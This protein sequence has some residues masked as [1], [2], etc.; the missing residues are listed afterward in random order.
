MNCD[1]IFDELFLHPLATRSREKLA[2]GLVGRNL[3]VEPA[4]CVEEP[5]FVPVWRVG[6]GVD[7]LDD[8]VIE[9][10]ARAPSRVIMTDDHPANFTQKGSLDDKDV[11]LAALEVIS[12]RVELPLARVA[13]LSIDG[14]V[15]VGVGT[16]A[17]FV[18]GVNRDLVPVTVVDGGTACGKFHEDVLLHELVTPKHG[19]LLGCLVQHLN[20]L[21]VPVGPTQYTGTVVF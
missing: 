19:L 16:R 20:H 8:D 12:A 10:P 14:D 7:V 1:K 9:L 17:A 18:R 6:C 15:N 3:L 4:V 13:V 2:F 11:R 21:A 5:L